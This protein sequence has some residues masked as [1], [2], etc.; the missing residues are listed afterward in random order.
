[1]HGDRGSTGTVAAQ[2]WEWTAWADGTPL[3]VYHFYYVMG[4]D[5]EPNW[6]I[7]DSRYRVVMEGDPSFEMTLAAKAESDGRHPFLGIDWT[8]LLGVTPIPQVCDAAPGVVTH[9]DL[10]VVQPRGLVRP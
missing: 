2:H 1:M 10:G 5:F 7:G 3:M 4:D 9:L 6:D 8:A